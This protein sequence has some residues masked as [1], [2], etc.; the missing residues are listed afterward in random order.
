MTEPHGGDPARPRM[1]R[2]SPGAPG[3][4]DAHARDIA[5]LM[6]LRDGAGENDLPSPATDG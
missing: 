3:G 6:T 5:T 2:P 1:C 4:Q